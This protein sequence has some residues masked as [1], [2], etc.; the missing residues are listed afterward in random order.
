ML[1]NTTGLQFLVNEKLGKR[2][3]FIGRVFRPLEMGKREYSQHA[4]H[5]V[6]RIVNFF[7][8][9][10]FRV[11]GMM[12][13]IGSRFIGLGNG[14]L[15]YSGLF[16][17]IFASAMVLGRLRFDKAREQMMVNA[18]DGVEFWF[19]RYNMMFPPSFLHN[20]VS[21]HFIEINNIYFCE[22][23]KKYIVARKELLA[24]RDLC[25]EEEQRSKYAMN[26]NYIYEPLKK[27]TTTILRLRGDGLF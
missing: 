9:G 7:W 22:M 8:V 10:I 1:K 27:D 21:A 5:R 11:Y 15:N 17:Y 4:L 3:G 23:L 25:S 2:A 16:C 18:Q 19:E 20:R 24:Q 12:R 6:F 13:P 26:P 14:P